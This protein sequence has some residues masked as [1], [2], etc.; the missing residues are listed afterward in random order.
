MMA[1]VR[2]T[3]PDSVVESLQQKFGTNVKLT[4]ITKDALSLFNWA[5][6]ERAQGRVVLSSEVD[7]QD[8]KQITTHTLDSVRREPKT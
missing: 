1:E 5:V 3:I 8:P 6:G 2:I 4:D 7:L